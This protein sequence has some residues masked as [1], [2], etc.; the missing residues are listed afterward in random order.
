VG[1]AIVDVDETIDSITNTAVVF[2]EDSGA[3]G[4]KTAEFCYDEYGFV[5]PQTRHPEGPDR[6]S[7]LDGCCLPTKAYTLEDGYC[8]ICTA[9]SSYKY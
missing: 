5:N 3:W 1:R 9:P 4:E 2:V 6:K 8:F 7:S